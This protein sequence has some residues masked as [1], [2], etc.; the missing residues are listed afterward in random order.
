MLSPVRLSNYRLY[1]IKTFFTP[2]LSL[3][4]IT[5][6]T[7][8]NLGGTPDDDELA[9]GTWYRSRDTLGGDY[10]FGQNLLNKK[11]PL[12]KGIGF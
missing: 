8:A 1:N 7:Y 2:S 12:A 4:V 3:A 9:M 5:N 10:P 11:W 6:G